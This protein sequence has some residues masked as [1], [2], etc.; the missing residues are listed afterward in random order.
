[1]TDNMETEEPA[2]VGRWDS[3]SERVITTSQQASL[4]QF[5]ESY[6][7]VKQK[8]SSVSIDLIYQL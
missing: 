4:P 5:E 1:M 8:E 2:V 7:S 3:I 6:N